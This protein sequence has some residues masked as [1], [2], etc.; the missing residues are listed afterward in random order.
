MDEDK[1]L[2]RFHGLQV[3]TDHWTSPVDSLGLKFDYRILKIEDS[4]VKKEPV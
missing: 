4:F 2:C 1:I 3:V